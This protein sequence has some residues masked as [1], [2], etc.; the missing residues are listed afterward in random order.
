VVTREIQIKHSV[1]KG[2]HAYKIRPPIHCNV[3]LRVD[4]EYLNI[5]DTNAMLCWIP[6]L[7]SYVPHQHD[8]TTDEKRILKLQDIVDLPVGH[9]PRGLAGA[10]R[11][12][13]DTS[14]KC[15]ISA[16]PTGEPCPSF[17]PW[18]PVNQK[19]GGVVI[20]ADFTVTC[21]EEH[22]A[23]FLQL[24]RTTLNAMPERQAMVLV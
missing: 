24:L 1:I 22:Y 5:S 2:Y 9:V 13:M 4:R 12:I 17:P 8:M 14:D 15:A 21:P 16:F 18:P 10:F 7:N 20:P 19:G 11:S 23:A 6:S 3:P